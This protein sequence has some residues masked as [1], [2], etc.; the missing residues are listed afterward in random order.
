MN[1]APLLATLPNPEAVLENIKWIVFGGF[2]GGLVIY[3]IGYF[4]FLKMQKKSREIG[5]REAEVGEKLE[6][7]PGRSSEVRQDQDQQG[8]REK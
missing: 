7:F 5:E 8:R 1:L 2:L 6:N 3:F 4:V